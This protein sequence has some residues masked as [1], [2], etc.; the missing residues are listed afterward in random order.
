MGAHGLNSRQW[1]FT[2]ETNIKTELIAE[3][4]KEGHAAEQTPKAG[5]TRF[6]SAPP[7]KHG[8]WKKA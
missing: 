5:P 7:R 4:T 6:L 1:N 2:S 3:I 8:S